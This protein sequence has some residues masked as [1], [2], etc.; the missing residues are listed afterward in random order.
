MASHSATM[1][2]LE[3]NRKLP[4]AAQATHNDMPS[5]APPKLLYTYMI[6]QQQ[7][8]WRW[9]MATRYTLQS[10]SHLRP[11][12]TATMRSSTGN[13][14]HAG[15]V[16]LVRP[17]QFLMNDE[18]R[19]THEASCFPPCAHYSTPGTLTS[20]TLY[21]APRRRGNALRACIG[22]KSAC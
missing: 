5:R 19:F 15:G 6:D 10:P 7:H 21:L 8:S 2:L 11:F 22:V 3:Q 13:H 4:K 1:V 20:Y 18:V 17:Y 12:S 16:S 14:V 9:R